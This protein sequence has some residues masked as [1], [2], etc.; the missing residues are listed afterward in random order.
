MKFKN[1]DNGRSFDFGKTSSE[2]A[3]Y[4]D[5]YPKEMYDKLYALGVGRKGEKWLDIGTGTGVLPFNLCH[6]GADIMG[7]DISEEQ[8]AAAK[9]I[10]K[11][12]NITNVCFKAAPAEKTDFP[13]NSFDCITA[14]QC[15]WYFDREKII[16]EI[17]RLIKPNG[18]FVKIYMSYTLDD[19]IADK[20]H[21]LVKKLNKNWTPA[22]S[23]SKDMYNHPFP[24]GDLDIFTCDIPFTRESWH[25]RMCACRGTMAS[26]DEKTLAEWNK[27][28]KKLLSKYPEEFTI[29]HK[30]YIAS[31]K[32]E[33]SDERI[34]AD[35][36]PTLAVFKK[37]R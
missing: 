5:I 2:Y 23:G 15:F 30:I 37:L 25:G 21:R 31:Y 6:T 32:I 33:N 17:K 10:L 24:N 28:H 22:A 12:R 8:I 14:A 35:G 27:E 1:I 18:V 13:D 29:K 9:N 7:I 4:R 19:E 3:K 20:S 36:N 16:S 34:V 11:E 26:M